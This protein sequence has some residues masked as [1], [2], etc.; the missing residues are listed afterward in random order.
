MVPLTLYGTGIIWSPTYTYGA[1]NMWSVFMSYL[2]LMA[3]YLI[4]NRYCMPP[5]Y[6]HGP[7]TCTYGP[8]CVYDINDSYGTHTLYKIGIWWSPLT[9]YGTG[10]IWF[11]P[12]VHMIPHMWIVFMSYDYCGPPYL[13]WDSYHMVPP[14]VP[15]VPPHVKCLPV[16]YDSYGPHT[17]CWIGIIWPP[18]HVYMVP[19][20][21]LCD[22]Y[23]PPIPI[24]NRYF[25][26][27][28]YLTQ[29]RYCMVHPHVHMVLPHVKCLHVLWILSFPT[30]YME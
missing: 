5:T 20:H 13:V 29:N 18:K 8:P 4:W 22:A 6:T 28:P 16:L 9:L 2:P 21:V 27:T 3:P 25:M 11:P 14:H 17:L 7:P 10:I 24:W 23:G 15:M 30:P 1:P 19:P 12:H 26:V